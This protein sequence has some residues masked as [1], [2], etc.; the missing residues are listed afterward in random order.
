LDY[1]KIDTEGAEVDIITGGLA[2]IRKFRPILS[3]EYGE[4]GYAAY[5]KQRTTLYDLMT[6]LDY[7]LFDLL[8]NEIPCA[9]EW[10]QCVDNFYWDFYAVPAE[11]SGQF[12][13]LLGDRILRAVPFCRA[14]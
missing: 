10:D 6:G 12:A 7:R 4:A 3:I 5:G 2:S 14:G 1:I 9:E 8:G 13:D 11:R